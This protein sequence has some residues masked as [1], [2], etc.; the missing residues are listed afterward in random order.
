MSVFGQ[1]NTPV[2]AKRRPKPSSGPVTVLAPNAQGNL[3][4]VRVIHEIGRPQY[5][6]SG[7]EPEE[8]HR[9]AS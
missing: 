1:F 9:P 2:K 8:T 4:P 6:K 5:G 7:F 3:V